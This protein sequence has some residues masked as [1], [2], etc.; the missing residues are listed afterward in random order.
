MSG[1]SAKNF[2]S[3]FPAALRLLGQLLGG[4]QGVLAGLDHLPSL[5]RFFSNALVAKRGDPI[6]GLVHDPEQVLPA[7]LVR[8]SGRLERRQR[9]ISIG[10]EGDAILDQRFANGVLRG[11]DRRDQRRL[12]RRQPVGFGQG[13]EVEIR[14]RFLVGLM[15]AAVSQLLPL[16]FVH[17]AFQTSEDG[18]DLLRRLAVGQPAANQVFQPRGQ[19]SLRRRRLG[20]KRLLGRRLLRLALPALLL[21]ARPGR[22]R[23]RQFRRGCR[24]LAGLGALR[25]R[26]LRRRCFG[27]LPPGG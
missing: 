3:D 26:L 14:R 12:G 5:G 18:V 21:L 23:R 7:L 22:L 2:F 17:Q 20:G 27:Q 1:R 9:L 19:L 25:A 10:R 16:P 11:I 15:L 13:G 6:R 8:R 4:G 24:R